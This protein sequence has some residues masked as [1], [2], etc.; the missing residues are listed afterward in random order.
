ME[1]LLMEKKTAYIVK[2]SKNPLP[3]KVKSPSQ[4]RRALYFLVPN[5]G[6]KLKNGSVIIQ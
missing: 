2:K 4:L 5:V 6:G 3:A 1:T